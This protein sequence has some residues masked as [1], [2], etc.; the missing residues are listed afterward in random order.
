MNFGIYFRNHPLRALKIVIT[1]TLKIQRENSYQHA[2]TLKK[3]LRQVFVM[4]TWS[5]KI[6][7][8]NAL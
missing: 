5:D 8:S 7:H 3:Y 1:M 2:Q 4:I 6:H